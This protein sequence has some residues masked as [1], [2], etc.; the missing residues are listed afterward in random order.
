[1]LGL[2]HLLD[3]AFLALTAQ[4]SFPLQPLSS[5]PS[6]HPHN[7]RGLLSYL[8]PFPRDTGLEHHIKFNSLLLAVI[9]QLLCYGRV[10]SFYAGIHRVFAE[11][12]EWQAIR[13]YLWGEESRLRPSSE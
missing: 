6:P 1:M 3:G 4:K 8:V 9:A 10:V 5:L 13:Q 12:R 2:R 11:L 7:S